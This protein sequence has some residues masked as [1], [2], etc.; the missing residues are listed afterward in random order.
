MS[1]AFVV[2]GSAALLALGACRPTIDGAWDGDATCDA[3][4]RHVVSALFN[5]Q[6]DGDLKG[7]IYIENIPFF[8]AE[9]TLRADIDKGEYDADDDEYDFD[10]EAD[11]EPQR[12]F[13]VSMELSGDSA[14]DL[15][16]DID[17]FDDDGEVT[18][19]CSLD[20]SRLS[21]TDD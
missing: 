10:L 8:G 1:R 9:L 7:Q 21:V 6:A 2:C 5:E 16:G 14:D 11:D 15:R 17:Q 4:G 13:Q 12:D 19:T 20:L 3:S 18:D